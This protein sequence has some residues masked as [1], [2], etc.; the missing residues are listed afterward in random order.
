MTNQEPYIKYKKFIYE[1]IGKKATI[2]VGPG[3]R[4]TVPISDV[5]E[6][7]DAIIKEEKDRWN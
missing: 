5:E 1:V 2:L 6:R 4:I 3:R 7:I